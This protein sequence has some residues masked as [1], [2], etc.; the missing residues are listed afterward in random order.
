MAALGTMCLKKSITIQV[1]LISILLIGLLSGLPSIAAL[2]GVSLLIFQPISA[3]MARM[4]S[5]D[6]HS[7]RR[8]VYDTT[9][10]IIGFYYLVHFMRQVVLDPTITSL[11]SLIPWIFA[12]AL[13]IV[14][15]FVR[16][17]SN[18]SMFEQ[19]PMMSFFGFCLALNILAAMYTSMA[20][21]IKNYGIASI[22][23]AGVILPFF[24]LSLEWK[25]YDKI[26]KLI[27][28]SNNDTKHD[29]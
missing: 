26:S 15:W 22:T 14:P 1:V 16:H 8:D 21:C 19:I 11:S 17:H 12:S 4:K 18:G 28:Y 20:Y 2:G 3:I 6:G 23:L 13:L 10:A 24:Y 29:K 9:I 27:Q 7:F 5:L 25:E